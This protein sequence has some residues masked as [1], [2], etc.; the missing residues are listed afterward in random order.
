MT[1]LP[2]A[3][4]VL[5][6]LLV[7]IAAMRAAAPQP[8]DPEQ[9]RASNYPGEAAFVDVGTLTVVYPAG[10]GEPVEANR[11]SAEARAKWLV[12][13]HKNKVDIAADDQV[14]EEQMKGNLLVLGWGNRVWNA[15]LSRPFKHDDAGTSFLGIKESDPDLDLLV[16][17]RNPL[18]PSTF[19]VFWSRI[20][21]E[22]DR[23]QVLPRVGSDW[24]MFKDYWPIRQGMFRPGNAWPPARDTTAEGDHTTESFASA[25]TTGTLDSERYHVYYD[26]R[27][28]DDAEIRAILKAREAALSKAIAGV[29][30]PP[31]RG[32]RVLLHVYED[33]NDK[34]RATGVADPT[35]AILSDREIHMT[36]R[37]ARSPAP[38]EEIH[39]V[40]REAFGPTPLSA[41][42]EGFALSVE[43]LWRG[44]TMDMHAALLRSG[45]LLPDLAAL[46]DE[47]RFRALPGDS[48]MASAGVFMT[49]IRE[50]YGNAGVKKAFA[51]QDG[52]V[53]DLAAALGATEAALNASFTGWADR[54][55]AAKKSELDFIAAERLAQGKQMAGDWAGMA[56][57][58]QQALRAKPD[59]PQTLFNLASAQMRGTDLGGAEAT[60]RRLL[61]LTLPPDGARFRIFGHYQLG[62]V[63]D[64]AGRRAEALAEYD[65]VLA[66]PDD[67]G[68]HDLA[69][70]RKLSPATRDQ[71]D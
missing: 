64:I 16:F 6:S 65:K 22:R 30:A 47:E 3:C 33:E 54:R 10:P 15:K 14:S 43:N 8:P 7:S 38:H 35:H 34:R 27:H 42:Y 13:V 57:A 61:S 51:L 69:R 59:D 39:L 24:A 66:L 11:R 19:V 17:H 1:P 20:D 4:L 49:W 41:V 36:H 29:G 9:H 50:T 12:A 71:L 55:V 58:L 40:A 37:F 56:A 5:A 70:E 52:R 21:P 26:K 2:R 53:S 32:F 46:L 23:F 67:H 44:D 18:N 48:G 45:G 31:P 63:L 62:R 68:A 60:L 28:I 25:G